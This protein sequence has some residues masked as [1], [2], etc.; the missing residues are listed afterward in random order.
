MRL[1]CVACQV[2]FSLSF[3]R[4]IVHF[5]NWLLFYFSLP[6]AKQYQKAAAREPWRGG[7][8]RSASQALGRMGKRGMV[9]GAN[10]GEAASKFWEASVGRGQQPEEREWAGFPSA[11]SLFS[12]TPEAPK[13]TILLWCIFQH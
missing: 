2:W 1:I 5:A 13:K 3:L 8:Q 4:V 9:L 10:V 12:F 11:L 7:L 6:L